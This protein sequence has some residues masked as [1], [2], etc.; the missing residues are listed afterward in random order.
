MKKIKILTGFA[1]LIIIVI[2]SLH[3]CTKDQG[4]IS[5]TDL[6]LAKDEA[7]T[8]A[9]FQELDNLVTTEMTNLDGNGYVS[10]KTAVCYTVTVDHPDST[11]FPKVITI[12]F[13]DG[14]STVFNGDTIT[15][16]G[17]I[18]VTNT[19]RWFIPGA[20]HIVTFQDF[21]FNGIKV[22]GTRTV[23]NEGLNEKNHLETSITLED[24][25]LTFPDETWISRNAY[26]LRELAR[27][28]DPLKDTIWI[29]G[30]AD[31][32]NKKGEEYVHE[33]IEPLVMV[34]CQGFNNRW[35][36]ADGKIQITNSVRG[37]LVID[38]SDSACTGNVTIIKDGDSFTYQFR[39]RN[40][41]GKNN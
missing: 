12:D 14:C 23:V 4:A 27:H 25:K 32:V 34:H 36:I 3:S 8:D 40:R 20:E 7:Y 1:S 11:I 41:N 24:G 35:M 30:S 22:E 2:L 6:S 16:S 38:Y 31:G 29:T 10:L 15:R 26:H 28:Q 13:G 33:I 9:L 19:G 21:Y 17:K 5:E 39:Y 18:I 37:S